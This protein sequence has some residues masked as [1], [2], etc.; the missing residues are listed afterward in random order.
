MYPRL[1]QHMKASRQSPEWPLQQRPVMQAPMW[2]LSRQSSQHLCLLCWVRCLH[3]H[4]HYSLRGD[5]VTHGLTQPHCRLANRAWPQCLLNKALQGK[6][7]FLCRQA[8]TCVLTSCIQ[9]PVLAWPAHLQH[10]LC[11][12]SPLVMPA[13]QAK[14]A[15]CSARIHTLAITAEAVTAGRLLSQNMS[16]CFPA[17]ACMHAF[18]TAL[19]LSI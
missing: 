5:N 8:L 17:R 12:N 2:R 6:H 19:S 16:S 1:H 4:D 13:K 9:L 3:A 7:M 18:I 11:P 10:N 14:C 15:A